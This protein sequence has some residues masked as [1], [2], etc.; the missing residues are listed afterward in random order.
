MERHKI[1]GYLITSQQPGMI[2]VLK[3]KTI[4]EV[5]NIKEITAGNKHVP[6]KRQLF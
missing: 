5:C 6:V 4:F 1:L 3:N 2:T